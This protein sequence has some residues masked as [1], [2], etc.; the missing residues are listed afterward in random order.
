MNFKLIKSKTRY[1]IKTNNNNNNNF[2]SNK[3]A[4][5]LIILI[6]VISNKMKL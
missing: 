5:N 2:Q 4:I 6:P 1:K 3:A